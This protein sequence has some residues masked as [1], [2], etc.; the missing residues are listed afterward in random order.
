MSR[1]PHSRKTRVA[2]LA[3][4]VITGAMVLTGCEFS[5]Y[6]MPLPG[7]ADLGDNPY[8]VKVKFRDVL[9][10]VPQSAVKVNDVS[11][12]RVDDI[13]VD[14]YQAEVTLLVNDEVELPDDALAR[15]RQTSLL[16]E[17]F[18][19]LEAPPG[20]TA[21]GQLE[22]G[23][24]IPLSRSGRNPEVEEVLGAMSL[25]LNGGG[26]AQLKTI[27]VELNKALEGRETDVKSLLG[28]LDLFTG[29]LDDGKE[30]IVDA[31]ESL[32]QLSISLNE[33]EETIKLALDE[34]PAGL[35]SIDRQRDDLIKMLDAL[36]RLSGVAVRVI[37]ASKQGT[38]DSFQHLD[39]ILTKLAESGDAFPK[40]LQVFLTYPFV[41]AVV[42]TNPAQARN[43][44]MGDYTNLSV[45]MDL[46]LDDLEGGLT[47]N[48][49]E[50][51]DAEL[52]ALEDQLVDGG[53]VPP[54]EVK[55]LIDELKK[56]GNDACQ[57]AF[58]ELQDLLGDDLSLKQLCKRVDA[59]GLPLPAECS[60]LGGGL[61]RGLPKPNLPN[62]PL[63]RPRGGNN[64]GGGGGGIDLPGGLNRAAPGS[65]ADPAPA[66]DAAAANQ[67]YDTDL[68]AML[69]WGMIR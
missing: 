65:L 20:S 49:C 9:D 3:A 52:D 24:L 59:I 58:D 47:P 40:S 29:Q 10:L 18:V 8:S 22:D 50:L 1:T 60:T 63:D 64:G 67:S 56:L 61:I 38:I 51:T 19:S 11:V 26:V 45:Q 55:A 44:H 46:N 37:Q 27:T 15:I 36:S 42:G 2:R 35:A 62:N 7:G 41:D 34:L 30:D 13:V 43:L 21:G 6:K 57:A 53:L 25:L 5:V 68:A 23:D 39:P 31:I 48:V 28:Q 14:G 54:D 69:V 66:S 4:A 17:K 33:E 12:G 16:G 32:N